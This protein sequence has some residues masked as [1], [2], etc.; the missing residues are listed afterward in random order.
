MDLPYRLL[1]PLISVWRPP[2]NDTVRNDALSIELDRRK[3]L[4]FGAGLGGAALL[5]A[6]GKGNGIGG[7][8]SNTAS[9][10]GLPAAPA[11]AN[12]AAAKKYSGSTVA[13]HIP[14]FGTEM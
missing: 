14:G 8:A 12:A 7:S 9:A 13:T 1:Q 2:M 6:C 3:A 11:V 10:A 4:R 5:A